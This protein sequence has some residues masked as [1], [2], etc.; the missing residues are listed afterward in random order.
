M[1]TEAINE[2][3][4]FQLYVPPTNKSTYEENSDGTL[5]IEGIASTSNKDLQGDIIL[6]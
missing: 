1:T 3:K 2:L 4:Q 5:T 6:F